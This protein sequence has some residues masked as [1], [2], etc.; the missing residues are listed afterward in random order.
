MW[1]KIYYMMRLFAQ[2]AHF[3]TLMTKILEDVRTFT[4]MLMIIL[5]AFA[6]FFYVIDMGDKE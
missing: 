2:T 4:I 1:I 3:I 6:N 5:F